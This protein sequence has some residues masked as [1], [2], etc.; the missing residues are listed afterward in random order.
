[1]LPTTAQKEK[2]TILNTV[3][4]EKDVDGFHTLNIG[5]Y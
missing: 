4:P 2:G 5:K 3:A 1:M